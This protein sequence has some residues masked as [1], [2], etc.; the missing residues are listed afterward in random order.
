MPHVLGISWDT[1]S[2]RKLAGTWA[3]G[4]SISSPARWRHLCS[5]YEHVSPTLVYELKHEIA[6][7]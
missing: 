4:C 6:D 1:V 2:G 3:P 5:F 7:S